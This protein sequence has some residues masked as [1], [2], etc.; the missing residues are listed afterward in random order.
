MMHKL[1]NVGRHW[2]IAGLIAVLVG[3]AV[4]YLQFMQPSAPTAQVP[5]NAAMPCGGQ[6]ASTASLGTPSREGQPAEFTTTGGDLYFSA[7][8]FEHGGMF[9]PK[10]GVTLL[11]LGQ[12]GDPP[13]YDRQSTTV[14]N[15]LLEVL[16]REREYVKQTLGAGQYWL[17][18][19]NS[20]AIEV[21]SCRPDGLTEAK[22]S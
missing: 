20:V 18:S 7:H 5:A 6:P 16:V 3:A 4:M 13:K 10:T 11:Y 2:L 17:L 21:M 15:T 9:D 14:S 22:P 8:G 12:P 19:S 1:K